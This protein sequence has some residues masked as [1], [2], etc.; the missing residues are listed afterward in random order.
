MAGTI[1]EWCLNMYERPDET[2]FSTSTALRV[3]RSGSWYYYQVF[4][5]AANRFRD[6][7]RFR[8]SYVGFRVV[9]SS[10]STER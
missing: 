9:C 7:P 8:D 10:P 2:E 5:R 3:L 1:W 6:D 4:A